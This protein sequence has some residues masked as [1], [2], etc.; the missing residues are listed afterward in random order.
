MP[1]GLHVVRKIRKGKPVLWY[2][3]AW[4]G[5]PRI[6]KAEGARPKITAAI[7]DEAATARQSLRR[8]DTGTL[9][10]LISAYKSPDTAE[11]QRLAKSTKANW[12]MWLDRIR[13]EFGDSPIGAF[14]DRRMR[15]DILDWRDRWLAQPRSADM[16]MQVFS[17][18]LS[19]GL[20]R[21]RL[22]TNIAAGVEQLYEADRSDVIWEPKHFE[23]FFAECS[24]EVRE[25]V[26]LA[27]CT[28]LRR[29]DLVALPWDAIKEHAIIWETAK[30]GRRNT[31]RIPLLPETRKLLARIKAR[32]EAEMAAKPERKRKPLP[33]TVLSNS[34]W[35][36]WTAM[37]FGSRFNDAKV[38]SKIEVNL[39]DLR[40]TFATR[41][42]LAELTD[43][44]IADILGWS[45]K[46]VSE[47]RVKYVD[48]ARVVIAIGERIAATSVNRV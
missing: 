14:N 48:Q 43:Q 7:T 19:W 47:I 26:E 8:D 42:M 23:A 38:A 31:A 27:A 39:H 21:G 40:G 24:V 32:H 22:T 16:A 12:S 46:D 41:C 2:V 20:D 25:G 29:G 33:D 44:Q 15:G 28:G 10:G 1:A 3:Y 11:W 18:L 35:R 9:G 45:T 17:R 13:L 34:R 6:H 4:R 36:P 37:G 5:G 30:S